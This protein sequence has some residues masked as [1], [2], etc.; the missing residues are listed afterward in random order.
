MWIDEAKT[1]LLRDQIDL[2]RR[3]KRN[4]EKRNESFE[5][6]KETYLEDRKQANGWF[7]VC[8]TTCKREG[9]LYVK[10]SWKNKGREIWENLG[11]S[12]LTSNF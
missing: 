10:S 9:N 8:G 6:S 5:W 12:L 3:E 11:G 1:K 4:N 2:Q 7:C